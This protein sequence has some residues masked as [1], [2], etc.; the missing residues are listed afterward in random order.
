MVDLN[1]REL[2]AP[3]RALKPEVK[4]AFDRLNA[5]WK[6]VV[7]ELKKITIPC[8]ISHTYC[9]NIRSPE[10]CHSLE[11]RKWRGK[12]RFCITYYDVDFDP[13]LGHEQTMDVTPYEEWSAEQ[14]LEMLDHVPAFF[15]TAV[16]QIQEFVA[17]TQED[18]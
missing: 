9:E 13:Q 15:E 5:K 3:L 2:S 10:Q 11:W 14:R 16:K 18:S 8:D 6:A 17:K 7:A 12:R 1:L 4:E